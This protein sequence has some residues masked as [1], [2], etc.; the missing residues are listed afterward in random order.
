MGSTAAPAPTAAPRPSTHR[1]LGTA[2]QHHASQRDA[3]GQLVGLHR[4]EWNADGQAGDRLPVAAVGTLLP[5]LPTD[6]PALIPAWVGAQLQKPSWGHSLFLRPVTVGCP[7][8][9]KLLSI[10]VHTGEAPTPLIPLQHERSESPKDPWEAD[11]PASAPLPKACGRQSPSPPQ[12]PRLGPIHARE[13]TAL[14]G[15]AAAA[16]SIPHTPRRLL[17]LGSHLLTALL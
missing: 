14:W 6:G 11:T 8:P 12:V 2:G 7:W 13:E 5:A 15:A 1:P 4:A 16:Q 9:P 3:D 17:S 10:S